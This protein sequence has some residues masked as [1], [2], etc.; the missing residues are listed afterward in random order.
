MPR[1][2]D[3]TLVSETAYVIGDVEIGE[4][5]SVWHGAVIRGDLGEGQIGAGM[6]IGSGTHIEDNAVVHSATAI[7]NNVV[8]G[9][10]AVVE[11]FKVGDNVLIG[12]NATLMATSEVGNFCVVAAGAVVLPGM[13][14]PDRSF[15]VGAP[16]QIKGEVSAEH[17]EHMRLT[18][19]LMAALAEEYKKDRSPVQRPE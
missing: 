4:N 19:S 15:V 13:R 16:A 1:I 10:G 8:I 12:N 3:S 5:S 14:I 17:I 6:R 11:A 9:H 2:A 7:G 18:R